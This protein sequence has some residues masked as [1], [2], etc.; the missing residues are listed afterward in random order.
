MKAICVLVHANRGTVGRRRQGK[1]AS[2]CVFLMM[3]R[4]RARRENS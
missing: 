2:S 4:A 3:M 1:Q